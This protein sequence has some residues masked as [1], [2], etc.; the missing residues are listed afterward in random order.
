MGKMWDQQTEGP[1]SQIKFLAR[2]SSQDAQRAQFYANFIRTLMLV[3]LDEPRWYGELTVLR[4]PNLREFGLTERN[5]EHIEMTD[6]VIRYAQPN[7]EHFSLG[8]GLSESFLERLILSCPK[9]VSLRFHGRS[10]RLVS[11]D[12]LVRFFVNVNPLKSLDVREALHECWSHEA[13]CVIMSRFDSLEDLVIP[14]IPDAWIASLSKV[15]PDPPAFPKMYFLQTGIAEKGLRF[16][17]RHAPNMEVLDIDLQNLPPT[18]RILQAA[19]SLTKLTHLTIN[20]G[21]KGTVNGNDLLLVAQKCPAMEEL[22]WMRE[23]PLGS[24]ECPP[25][26]LEISDNL[27]EEVSK[28]MRKF[29]TFNLIFDDANLLTHRSILTI[30]KHC[31]KI[32]ELK[33]SCTVNWRDFLRGLANVGCA[34]LQKLVIALGSPSHDLRPRERT[35]SDFAARLHELAPNLSVFRLAGGSQTGKALAVAFCDLL[36]EERP[37]S[38]WGPSRP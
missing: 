15:S 11:K 8:A 29:K 10:E 6:V 18:S 32:E 26:G 28:Y 34:K 21:L 7:L 4:F 31:K 19:S 22:I 9:L 27:I 5:A 25:S 35:I 23:K 30:I 37:F 36:W 24:R 38:Y 12:K 20:F 1:Q 33:I 16:L 17:A 3:A 13:F 14:N 2:L